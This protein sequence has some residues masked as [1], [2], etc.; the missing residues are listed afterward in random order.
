M[1]DLRRIFSGLRSQWTTF[2]SLLLKNYTNQR[3]ITCDLGIRHKNLKG[4]EDLSCEFPDQ[5]EG[6]PLVP[7]L[8]EEVVEVGGEDFKH[9]TLVVAMHK[10]LQQPHYVLLVSQI[11]LIEM[12]E[13]FEFSLGLD[14]EGSSALDHLNGHLHPIRLQSQIFEIFTTTTKV[15]HTWSYAKITCPK[16]PFPNFLLYIY[17]SLNRSWG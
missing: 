12:V 8:L 2:T 14:S 6:N 11:P 4:Y 16:D 15:D 9:K 7:S 5:V 1:D 3:Q 17:L 13:E 10:G